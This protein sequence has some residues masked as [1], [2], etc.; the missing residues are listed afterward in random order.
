[1]PAVA[2]HRATE[3]LRTFDRIKLVPISIVVT[4]ETGGTFEGFA[5]DGRGEWE[6]NGAESIVAALTAL[7]TEVTTR[8]VKNLVA[9]Y[10]AVA[11]TSVAL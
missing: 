2:P 7:R 1:M 10:L 9:D 11:Q 4:R 6:V 5:T 8:T 3:V